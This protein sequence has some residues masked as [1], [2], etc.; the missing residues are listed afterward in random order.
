MNNLHISQLTLIKKS[1][2]ILIA[3][4]FTTACA[5]SKIV[6]FD[7]PVTQVHNLND[8]DLDGV[9]EARE[10]CDET[11]LGASID[12]D[13]CGTTSPRTEPFLLDIKFEN[14]SYIVPQSDLSEINKLAELLNKHQDLTV[15]IE[16]HSSRVGAKKFNQVLSKNR[17]EAVALVL[18]NDFNINEER[19]SSIGYGYERLKERGDTEYAHSINRRIMIELSYVM[20]IDDMKWTI[21]TVDK[22]Q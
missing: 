13:G 11:T 2:I 21:Y 9:I 4:L 20:D 3:T 1:L 16:G 6:S 7:E 12:N 22:V 5:D 8:I 18:I 14:N 17:A 15:L 19:L 10:K